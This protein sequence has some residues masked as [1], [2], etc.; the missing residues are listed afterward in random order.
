MR[1]Y[2]KKLMTEPTPEKPKRRPR[3]GGKNPRG[4]HQKYKELQPQKYPDDVAK[5]LAAGKTPAGMHRPIMVSEILDVL[6]P[7]PG[8]TAVDCTLGFGGHARE[9][10]TRIQPSGRLIGQLMLPLVFVAQTALRAT[11]M[12]RRKSQNQAF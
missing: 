9:L 10:L 6:Q 1:L 5:V 11:P 8:E 4:F 12:L 7:Q 3:Y 2:F